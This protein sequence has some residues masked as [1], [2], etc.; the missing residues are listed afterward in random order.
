[1]KGWEVKVELFGPNYQKAHSYAKSDRNI[2]LPYM[3]VAVAVLFKRYTTARKK[4]TRQC[5]LKFR[6]VYNTASLPQRLDD[7]AAVYV[8][9]LFYVM[10]GLRAV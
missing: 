9:T 6:V 7:S 5:P 2:R 4:S 1:L 8:K 3:Y 10:L